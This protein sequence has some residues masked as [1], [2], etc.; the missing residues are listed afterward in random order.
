MAE[1][2]VAD[3]PDVARISW[4]FGRWQHHV[5]YTVFK[6]NKLK[7]KENLI[8]KDRINNYGM[9]LKTI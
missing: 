1:S 8:I 9:V 7:L 6:R 4:K 3:H 5:D 2:L